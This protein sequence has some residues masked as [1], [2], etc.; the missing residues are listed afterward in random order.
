MILYFFQ[1]ISILLII[2]SICNFLT[3]NFKIENNKKYIFSVLIIICS[4]FLLLKMIKYLNLNSILFLDYVV[5]FKYLFFILLTF[6]LLHIILTKNKVNNIDIWFVGTYATI[7]IL[8]YDRYFLD[9]DEFTYWGQRVK[10]FY[11][12]I[13][14]ENFKI[15]RYHQ[16]LLTSWQLFVTLNAGVQENILIFAN[17]IILIAGFFFIA[18]NSFKKFKVNPKIFIIYF[19]L[20]YLLTNNLSF[21]FVSIYADP[22]LA[23]LSACILK[24]IIENNYD[25]K[26]IVLL[27]LLTFCVYFVHRLGIIFLIMLLPYILL[28]NYKYLFF[29]NKKKFFISLIIIIV[30]VRFLFF[31]QLAY[32]QTPFNIF[33]RLDIIIELVYNF[34]LNFKK[35]F[36]VNIYYSSFGVSL[37]KIIEII[38]HKKDIINNLPLNILFW[39]IIIIFSSLLSEKKDI[40]LYFIISLIFYSLV[41]YVEKIHFQKLSYLVFGRYMSILLLSYLLFFTLKNK[42]IYLLYF[43]LIFNLS[44]TPLK[45]LGFFV[46][47]NIYYSYKKNKNYYENRN[48]IKLLGKKYASCKNI[49]AIYDKKNFPKYLNGHYSLILNI[50]NY[51]I[52]FSKIRFQDIDELRQMKNTDFFNFFDCVFALNAEIND[53]RK[54][55]FHTNNLRMISL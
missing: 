24:L 48:Q 45:S 32:S 34:I 29:D 21:G 35:I 36:L 16:P 25:Q 30:A 39:I 20:F 28:K 27:F 19:F 3:S 17:N 33:D 49:F 8:C 26:R 1:S 5:V 47:D 41:I 55:N 51:E 6:S 12:Y 15:N 53:L 7:S 31:K 37:N 44:I 10:D 52:F 13:D 42:N 2:L 50:F 18:D 43:L 11:Y 22:I 9:E 4:C 23:V 40:F 46:P 38:I 14:T 54:Y